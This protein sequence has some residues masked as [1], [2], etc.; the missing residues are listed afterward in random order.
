VQ[1]H[2]NSQLMLRPSVGRDRRVV[3]LLIWVS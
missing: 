2:P 1:H 3:L